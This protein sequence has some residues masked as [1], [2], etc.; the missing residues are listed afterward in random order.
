V[1]LDDR[2]VVVTGGAS[3]IGRALCRR[4]AAAGARAVVVADLAADGARAVA[5]E[6]NDDSDGRGSTTRALAVPTDV[7]READINAVVERTEETFGP[8]D[9]FCSNAGIAIGGGAEVP[10]ESWERI[11]HVNV[12][13]HVY[14]ARAVL[15]GM[16]A[17]GEGYLL[18]TAS[19]AGLLTNLGAAPYSVTKHAAVGLAEWLAITHGPAGIKVSCLCPQGVRTAMLLGG[20][21]PSAPEGGDQAFP[22]GQVVLASGEMLEPDDVA[23]AVVEGLREETFL[24]L[25]HPEVGEYFRHKATDYDRW[26][27]GMRRLQERL[28]AGA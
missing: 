11:W 20:L 24:I 8:I 13:A 12:M 28:I 4:F 23:D 27:R 6:I 22:A 19:A 14:A 16:I 15:P 10:D 18:N 7:T 25:P 9:L 1:E 5:A 21:D 26:L 3:G 2:V 17:R